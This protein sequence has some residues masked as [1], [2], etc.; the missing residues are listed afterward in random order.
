MYMSCICL[1]SPMELPEDVV[2][3]YR[4]LLSLGEAGSGD[5]A[6]TPRQSRIGR[7]AR[8]PFGETVTTFCRAAPLQWWYLNYQTD[9]RP[10]RHWP[11]YVC[12]RRP[13]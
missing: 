3:Y 12:A 1:V 4:R 8:N 10:P 13:A 7:G 5:P 6:E 9:S 2:D 11:K